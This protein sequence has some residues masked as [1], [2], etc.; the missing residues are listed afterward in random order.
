METNINPTGTRGHLGVF[1]DLLSPTYLSKS[2]FKGMPFICVHYENDVS[3]PVLQVTGK[4]DNKTVRGLSKEDYA[5]LVQKVQEAC[6]TCSKENVPP[7]DIERI[8]EEKAR[9]YGCL[10]EYSR[11]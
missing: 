10:D 4:S 7:K 2:I 6:P 8:F 9:Q 5:A 1:I 11:K 3:P